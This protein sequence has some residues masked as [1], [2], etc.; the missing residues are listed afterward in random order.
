MKKGHFIELL[1]DII[2]LLIGLILSFLSIYK[3]PIL[4][5]F[6]SLLICSFLEA[7][8]YIFNHDKKDTLFM[9]FALLISAIIIIFIK[10]R[11]ALAFAVSFLA[12]S[13][14]SFII[15]VYSLRYIKKEKIKL[16]GLR[17]VIISIFTVFGILVS[18]A[19][20]Y[21]LFSKI[22]LLSLLL[23]CFGLQELFCDMLVHIDEIKNLIKG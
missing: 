23:S 3:S 16:L 5:C 6:L 7:I 22:Y 4:L 11:P 10:G 1:V 19:T 9:S 14:L 13:V 18:I 20:Y 12:L 17:Y 21:E 15:K 2:V 8:E